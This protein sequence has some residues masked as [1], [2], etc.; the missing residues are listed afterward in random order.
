MTVPPEIMLDLVS[1][2]G[3]ISNSFTSIAILFLGLT[4]AF[5]IARKVI[6]LLPLG[7]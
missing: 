7:K 3:G 2:V 1:A 4:M 5:Y 6:Q